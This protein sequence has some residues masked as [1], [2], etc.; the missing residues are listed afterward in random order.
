MKLEA[1]DGQNTGQATVTFTITDTNDN[2]PTFTETFYSFNVPEDS[3]T[4]TILARVEADD[5]DAGANGEVTYSMT[6]SWAQ[7]VFQLNPNTGVIVLASQVDF[8]QV[9]ICIGN[10]TR[11]HIH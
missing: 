4:G 7:D 2:T 11:K 10:I 1:T 8:E 5:P 6:S 9:C 3:P